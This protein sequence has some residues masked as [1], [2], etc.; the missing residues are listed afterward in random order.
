MHLI[1]VLHEMKASRMETQ[2]RQ[3]NCPNL[4]LDLMKNGQPCRTVTGQEQTKKGET[5]EGV[6]VPILLGLCAAFFLSGYKAR[7]SLGWASYGPLT[8]KVCQESLYVQALQRKTRKAGEN[9]SNIFGFYGWLWAMG[10]LISIVSLRE[11]RVW[12]LRLD[13]R[14]NEA[15]RQKGRRSVK[16][17]LLRLLLRLLLRPLFCGIKEARSTRRHY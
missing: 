3:E 6:S 12:F 14:K 17:V 13:L 1:K 8:N 11:Q 2:W 4:C 9:Q 5:Q 16:T 7:P 10:V 15:G